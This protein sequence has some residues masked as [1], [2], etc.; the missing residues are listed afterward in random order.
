MSDTVLIA[1][2]AAAPAA[3]AAIAGLITAVKINAVHGLVNG[4]VDRQLQEL[5]KL[6]S[7]LKH[8]TREVRRNSVKLARYP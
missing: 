4:K 3:I 5:A 6:R 7:T 8:L 2:L 1:A